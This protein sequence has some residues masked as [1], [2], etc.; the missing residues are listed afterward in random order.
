MLYSI[1]KYK[2]DS[3]AGWRSWGT[4]PL[5]GRQVL[6]VTASH[7]MG[8]PPD[9]CTASRWPRFISSQN[10]SALELPS[11]N[12]QASEAPWALRQLGG[13]TAPGEHGDRGEDK[14]DTDQSATPAPIV[15]P[16]Q[17]GVKAA[18]SPTPFARTLCSLLRL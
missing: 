18:P 10:L 7:R 13:Y 9:T 3:P 12:C 8:T 6:R 17:Q 15:F 4:L 1:T 16:K 5:A 2:Y 11:E 14:C